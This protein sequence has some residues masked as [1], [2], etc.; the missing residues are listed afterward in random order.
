MRS[1]SP[2]LTFTWTLIVSPGLNDGMSVR[3][4]A[5]DSTSFMIS[6]IDVTPVAI[7]ILKKRA[8]SI[9]ERRLRPSWERRGL[10]LAEP[11]KNFTGLVIEVRALQKVGPFLQRG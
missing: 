10:E 6:A 4:M 9:T 5:S 2:S 11:A 1:L 8:G 7:A 3:L